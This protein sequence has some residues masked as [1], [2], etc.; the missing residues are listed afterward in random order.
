MISSDAISS[1]A[2]VI[3]EALFN[4]LWQ[5]IVLCILVG[6]AL[7]CHRRANAATRYAIWW[8]ALVVMAVLPILRQSRATPQTTLPRPAPAPQMTIL[9]QPEQPAPSRVA[10]PV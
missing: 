2:R 6:C 4:G 8:M 3:V 5:G 7:A 9:R 10:V 1:L